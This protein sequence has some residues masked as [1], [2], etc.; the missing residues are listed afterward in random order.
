MD[1][2]IY[3]DI[4]IYICMYIIYILG[5]LEGESGGIFTSGHYVFMCSCA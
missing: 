3:G 1:T 5:S 2:Y 4:Y